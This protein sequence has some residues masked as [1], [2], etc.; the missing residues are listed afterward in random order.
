VVRENAQPG[1]LVRLTAPGHSEEV[2]VQ[3]HRPESVPIGN[4]P[5]QITY[6]VKQLPLGFGLTLN[7]FRI[8][9]YPGSERHRSYES[10][11][12]TKD[13]AGGPSRDHLISMNQPAKIAGYTLF[14]SSYDQSPGGPTISYLSVS[15]DPGKPVVFAGYIVMMIG[16][17]IVIATRVAKRRAT[18]AAG[19]QPPVAPAEGPEN[20]CPQGAVP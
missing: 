4:T 16:M 20:D 14:Q 15:R 12:T 11:I 17:L 18:T 5:Y 19:V 6:S 13:P 3:R 10:Q 7:S 9:K 1:I 8:G 2:W